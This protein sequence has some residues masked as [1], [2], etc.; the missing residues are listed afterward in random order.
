MQQKSR[1]QTVEEAGER[2]SQ[3]GAKEM[4]INRDDYKCSYTII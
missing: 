4:F 3:M 2:M 1:A